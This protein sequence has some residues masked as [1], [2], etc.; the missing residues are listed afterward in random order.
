MIA[1]TEYPGG[2]LIVEENILEECPPLSAPDNFTVPK[3]LDNRPYC[4]APS[5]Q[6]NLPHCAGYSTAG[7]VEVHNWRTRH[8][9]EQVDGDAIY[10]KAKEIEGNDRDG[11]TLTAACA[12]AQSL[13]HIPADASVRVIKTMRDVQFALH[14]HLA[15]IA[16]FMITKDW[17][18]IDQETGFIHTEYPQKIGG[19][20]VLLCWYDE[21]SVG[22][23]NSWGMNYGYQGFF[24]LTW[25]QF[26]RQFLYAAVI[27]E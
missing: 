25:E 17:N 26:N 23:Q 8:V 19:H 3:Y 5:N 13:G 2:D 24:R 18:R 21:H 16:G 10:L 4:L 7:Y 12:A 6:G 20:A 1:V 9:A 14:T 15:C 27:E 22:G 11:T